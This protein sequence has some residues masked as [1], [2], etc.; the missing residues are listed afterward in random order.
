[1]RIC[2]IFANVLGVRKR[3]QDG[4]GSAWRAPARAPTPATR[5]G[6]MARND[7]PISRKASGNVAES[8]QSLRFCV[9]C[10]ISPSLNEPV[11]ASNRQAAQRVAGARLHS[12]ARRSR[13]PRHPSRWN[14]GKA[15]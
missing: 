6:S 9:S 11:E 2:A 4:S 14:G 15:R 13:R 5:S 3:L 12:R 8:L 10:C 7:G 1:M